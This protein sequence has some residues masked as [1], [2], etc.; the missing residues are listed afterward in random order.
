M[1]KPPTPL[2]FHTEVLFKDKVPLAQ[3]KQIIDTLAGALSKAILASTS[4]DGESLNDLIDS[5]SV[6][7]PSTNQEISIP[8]E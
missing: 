2:E 7:C 5:V 4:V 1:A 8:L 3:R 6:Y